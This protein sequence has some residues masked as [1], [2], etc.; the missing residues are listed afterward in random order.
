MAA[1][2][3]D[4]LEFKAEAF[5][6]LEE[7]E[8][9]LLGIEQGLE[10]SPRF[11]AIF[12]CFH[13]L[14]GAAGMLELEALRAHM[15]QIE[16][17]FS[18]FKAQTSLP[19]STCSFFLEAL[20]ASRKILNNEAIEFSYK[21]PELAPK[22]LKSSPATQAEIFIVDD[23]EDLVEILGIYM[24]K[25]GYSWK[26]FT[27]PL[28]VLKELSNGTP[29]LI[30]SD[31]SMPGLSGIQLLQKVREEQPELPFIFISAH[32]SKENL[33]VAVAEG[34]ST[35]IEKPFRENQVIA[36]VSQALLH[37]EYLDLLNQAFDMLM[38]QMPDLE[39]FLKSSGKHD[40]YELLKTDV[41]KLL[42][43]RRELKK[44]MTKKLGP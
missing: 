23:E 6:L 31:I 8:T 24:N 13:S 39:A 35:F 43:K 11:N 7:A 3:D 27:D 1:D 41:V 21:L 14:K 15:H 9:A 42:A 22:S 38:F 19:L 28:E 12:R 16:D 33:L 37:K 20:D 2:E 26:G 30:I 40:I 17:L 34:V 32:L 44:F 18:P 36:Q 29:N 5:D 25:C 4:V 10:F